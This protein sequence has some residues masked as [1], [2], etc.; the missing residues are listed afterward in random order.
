MTDLSRTDKKFY[1]HP[2]AKAARKAEAGSLSL[3]LICNCWCRD[4]RQQGFVPL[5][6]AQ[7]FGSPAEIKALVDSHLWLEVQGGYQ[8]KNWGEWNPDMLKQGPR[9]SAK[10][11]VQDVLA[12]HPQGVQD[13]LSVEVEKLIG[14]GVNSTVLIAAL[15]KWNEKPEARTSWLAY[16]VSDVIREG[17]SGVHAAIRKA[18]ESGDVSPLKAFGF[19]WEAPVA[20]ERIG[21][22]RVRE[23][24]LQKKMQWLNEVEAGLSGSTT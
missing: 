3:W 12:D 18:R 16:Y 22:K 7:G 14:E 15:R 9:T 5:D 20:P 19:R 8:F 6:V 13:R 1:L 21:A 23:F 17:E 10:W 4:H 2:K 11:L 24:M